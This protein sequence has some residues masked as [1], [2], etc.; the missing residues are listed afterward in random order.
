[1]L[2]KRT[3]F[4]AFLDREKEEAFFNEMNEKGWKLIYVRWAF[5]TFA[6][7]EKEQYKTV[8]HYVSR[9]GETA[10]VRTVTECGYEVVHRSSEGK[11]V[12]LYI[13][14]PA[15]LDAGD[16]LTDN[17]SKL[18]SAK[19]SVISMRRDLALTTLT[20][21][22]LLGIFLTTLPS[23]IKLIVYAP[24]RLFEIFIDDPLG[25]FFYIALPLFGVII[26]VMALLLM[27][28]MTRTK[29]RISKLK[30]EMKIYE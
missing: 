21:A 20:S 27:R 22:L 10:L 26:G 7:A 16:F 19:K 4:K 5:Y 28:I 2:D 11:N 1:M 15:S 25:G 30:A 12:L 8:L 17:N 23:L 9:G 6:K 14:I 13:N 3:I 24:E 18:E 29:K